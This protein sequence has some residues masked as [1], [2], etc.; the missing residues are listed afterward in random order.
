MEVKGKKVQSQC[1]L[2]RE[3]FFLPSI[4]EV[5]SCSRHLWQSSGNSSSWER[6]SFSAIPDTTSNVSSSSS[7]RRQPTRGCLRM[8][9]LWRR[10]E[11]RRRS[12]WI[13]AADALLGAGPEGP[14]SC[15]RTGWQS[16]EP[17]SA[18]VH[19]SHCP[20][21]GTHHAS[22][23]QSPSVLHRSSRLGLRLKS[24]ARTAK[25]R[26]ERVLKDLPIPETDDEAAFELPRCGHL[27]ATL[28]RQ[29]S[30]RL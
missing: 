20:T 9:P 22:C 18:W 26:R 12:R 27:S 16:V 29:V 1:S 30:Q 19:R 5:R 4:V 3:L 17:A 10:Q 7:D 2:I 23:R 24:W 25:S 21:P 13:L 8:P 15:P 6:V 11:Q 14:M 28:R